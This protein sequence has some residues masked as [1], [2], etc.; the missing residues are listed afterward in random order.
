MS[1]NSVCF[2]HGSSSS[3]DNRT[4]FLNITQ[5]DQS[6]NITDDGTGQH[7]RCACQIGMRST[8]IIGNSCWSKTIFQTTV[9]PL[10]RIG[11]IIITLCFER[12]HPLGD[13]SLL[14]GSFPLFTLSRTL[15]FTNLFSQL[16]SPDY[17][18]GIPTYS[19]TNSV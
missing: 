13:Q 3:G 17:C 1:G 14:D 9:C 11:A 8:V 7:S 2:R 12:I 5:L 18:H 6:E 15:S 10:F 4:S 16:V 19:R